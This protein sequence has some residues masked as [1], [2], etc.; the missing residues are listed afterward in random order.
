MQASVNIEGLKRLR[1][2]VDANPALGRDIAKAWEI[3]YRSFTRLRFL[4]LSRSGGG[5]EWPALKPSTIARRRK[6]KGKGS[7][8]IL[9]DTGMMFASLQPSLGGNGLLQSEPLPVG[10]TAFL[11]GDQ[12][13]KNGPTLQQ[14]A[15]WQHKGAGRLPARPILAVPESS[16]IAQM[17][18]KAKQIAVKYLNDT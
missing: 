17:S 6:G 13:Y 18:A 10:F 1:K 12:Q 15:V 9:R 4:R 16:T 2:A 3:I 8:A 7:A 14:V 11:G 5:G